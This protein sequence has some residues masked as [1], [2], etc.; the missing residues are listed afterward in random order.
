MKD[1]KLA[2]RYAG[3]LLS[4]FPD[5]SQAESTDEFLR[6]LS[7]AMEQSAE[8]RDVMLDPAF[9]RSSRKAVLRSLAE[10]RGL[11]DTVG[12]FMDTLVDNNRVGVI[13]TIALV[14]HEAREEAL[15]IVPAEITTATPLEGTQQDRARA[16]LE[17]LTGRKV[18][19]SCKVDS[20]L[21][22]GAV[23]KIGSKVYDG[24]LRSHLSE[25]RR[26]MAQE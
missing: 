26:R 17:R 7:D 14:F 13:P 10:Q 19:L 4:V 21:L 2:S 25:L 9:P 3:A 12:R 20:D 1:R 6:A 8:F 23:T 22:G 18:R 16:A 5:P 11:P 15:G 24:S